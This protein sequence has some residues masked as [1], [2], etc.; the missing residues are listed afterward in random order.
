MM[1]VCTPRV[2]AC[3]CWTWAACKHAGLLPIVGAGTTVLVAGGIWMRMKCLCMHV[4]GVGMLS[5]VVC[6]WRR[7]LR[8]RPALRK[9]RKETCS[10]LVAAAETL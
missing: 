2:R 3:G 1:M 10:T 8:T 9:I 4:V 6:V 7:G 5:H